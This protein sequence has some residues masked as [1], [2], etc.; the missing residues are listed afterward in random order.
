VRL[1]VT[2]SPTLANVLLHM[3]CSGAK[4]AYGIDHLCASLGGGIKGGFHAKLHLWD[5]H[6]QEEEW[7]FLLIDAK[8]AHNKQNWI[9]RNADAVDCLTQ[10]AIR[11][12]I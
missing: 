12:H 10:V 6:K 9:D 11:C 3:F 8:H 4:E 7:R 1:S 5:L 2:L